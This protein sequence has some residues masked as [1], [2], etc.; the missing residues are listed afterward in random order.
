MSINLNNIQCLQNVMSGLCLC[1]PK[2][3]ECSSHHPATTHHL[4]DGGDGGEVAGDLDNG[5]NDG[6]T[7]LD[8]MGTTRVSRTPQSPTISYAHITPP[9]LLLGLLED[10]QKWA[11]LM[12]MMMMLMQGERIAIVSKIVT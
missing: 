12:I 7:D 10:S 5:A 6:D 8:I 3:P 4:C 11:N 1:V 9:H 2:P